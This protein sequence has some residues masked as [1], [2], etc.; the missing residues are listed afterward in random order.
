[1]IVAGAVA[2]GIAIG[3]ATGVIDFGSEDTLPPT[4]QQAAPEQAAPPAP[5]AEAPVNQAA[6]PPPA[7][8]PAEPPAPAP[9]AAP[10]PAPAP[11][12][13]APPAPAAIEQAPQPACPPVV[14]IKGGYVI[15]MKADNGNCR[16]SGKVRHI[17]SIECTEGPPGWIHKYYLDDK[18]QPVFVTKCMP[19]PPLPR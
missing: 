2:A 18:R 12:P 17:M 15:D 3:A 1:L 14:D 6:V 16:K 8:A 13:P 9:V 5:A 10:A 7:P 4:Q 11:A 19:P